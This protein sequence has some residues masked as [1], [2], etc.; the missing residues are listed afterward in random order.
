MSSIEE[1]NGNAPVAP[2]PSA[3]APSGPDQRTAWVLLL[4]FVA[5]ACLL[6]IQLG[7][8]ALWDDESLDGL[9]A[10]S[11]LLCGDT[12]ADVGN[13]NLALYRGGLL[14]NHMRLEGMPPLTP[15]IAA[16]SMQFLGQTAFAA[17]LPEALAG[18]ACVA[19][20]L[21]WVWKW[22]A[23]CST[24]TVF[25][26]A[27]L[28]NVSFF[29]YCRQCH[30]YAYCILFS[31]VMAYLYFNGAHTKGNLV[32]MG[33]CGALLMAANQ[34]ICVCVCA[35]LLVDYCIWQRKVRPLAPADWAALLLPLL[36]MGIVLA[37]WW[38]PMHTA[39][40]EYMKKNTPLQRLTLFYWNLRD[41]NATE[42]VMLCSL[43]LA[44]LAAF[45]TRDSWL[46]RALLAL[47]IYVSVMTV[48]SNQPVSETNVADVR[49][50]S[51]LL[52]LFI[53]VNA[54]TLLAFV[55]YLKKKA[56][57][58]VPVALVL[59]GTNVFYG[60]RPLRSTI[61]SFVGELASPIPDPYMMASN[62]I[63]AHVQPG[64]TVAVLPQHP[65][66]P[67]MF[68]A[69]KALYA[70]QIT[71]K[72]PKG[73]L[74]RLPAI[75]F[76]GKVPPKYLIVFGPAIGRVVDDLEARRY[77]VYREEAV[78]PVYWRDLYRPELF[79]RSFKPVEFDPD[80]EAIYIFKH[81]LSAPFR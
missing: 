38:N 69:P 48:V 5:S 44:P 58:A 63:N 65:T 3:P 41:A 77:G 7:H 34:P 72:N 57:V 28:C 54:F 16:C 70:W 24:A 26:I 9:G 4:A 13:H 73:E 53:A 59:F 2:S 47:F 66:Q 42:M 30:Y 75:H 36:A 39:L 11:V 49:F 17:R 23:A 67:L 80:T 37:L 81:A 45:V 61:V 25:A 18:L 64:E 56:W 8:Y 40:G 62:W 31:V 74:A 1:S 60:G 29:L 33:M 22:R 50:L 71:A 51:P 55:R 27:L 35:C 10:R 20:M 79:W 21:C 68:L 14:L 78:L 15:Y 52:P 6:F 46:K 43:L 32:A 12:T 76:Q 19:L